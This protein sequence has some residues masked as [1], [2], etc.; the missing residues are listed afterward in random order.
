LALGAACLK[1]LPAVEGS[2]AELTRLILGETLPARRDGAS[3]VALRRAIRQRS[4]QDF[5]ADR[6]VVVDGWV[7]SLAETR[8][9][10]LATLL[11]NQRH[12]AA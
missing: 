2:E 8:V 4:R 3:P 12:N 6:I 5:S 7:L 10:A 9:Y 1:A 11:A